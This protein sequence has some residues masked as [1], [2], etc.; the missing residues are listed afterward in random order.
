MGITVQD[1]LHF[2]K[3]LGDNNVFISTISTPIGE[4]LVL[5]TQK[6][7][8]LLEF[9]DR[10]GLEGEV[11]ALLQKAN[12]RIIEGGRN[13]YSLLSE[14]L[15]AYFRDPSLP[16]SV[17]LDLLGSDF[18]KK[19]WKTLI[20]I[21]VGQ[22]RTYSQVAETI[23]RSTAA[24]AVGHANAR[25][26]IAIVI[27]CHRLIGANGSLTGYGGGIWRKEWLLKHERNTGISD[28]I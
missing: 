19:V 7:I 8:C 17:T 12:G 16:F 13:F 6:G 28:R 26:P 20:G 18:Q 9:E 11:Q 23:G 1:I 21:P 24:R 27:P 14:E 4:M 5:E 25:N 2:M 22:T 3:K 15:E 10:E